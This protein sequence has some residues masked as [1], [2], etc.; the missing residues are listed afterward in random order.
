LSGGGADAKGTVAVAPLIGTVEVTAAT[1]TAAATG[2]AAATGA[3]VVVVVTLVVVVVELAGAATASG[4][5]S[6]LSFSRP[7]NDL[8][9]PA[10]QQR[11]Q[12]P[13]VLAQSPQR[14][15]QHGFA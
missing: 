15:S 1:G 3:L 14:Q 9:S 12:A 10:Q 4:S 11:Q 2:M 5:G 6:Y 7:N 8:A 13:T